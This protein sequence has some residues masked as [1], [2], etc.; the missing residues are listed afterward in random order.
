MRIHSIGLLPFCLA[1]SAICRLTGTAPDADGPYGP[2]RGTEI[3]AAAAESRSWAQQEASSSSTLSEDVKL[4]ATPST[5]GCGQFSQ[6]SWSSPQGSDTE[7]SAIG[8]V[9]NQGQQSM[10]PL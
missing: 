7:I 4:V 5:V 9:S 10:S 8:K 1:L 2:A 3:A 6:L